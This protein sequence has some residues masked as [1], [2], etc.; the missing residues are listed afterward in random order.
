MVS[1]L[2]LFILVWVSNAHLCSDVQQS[3][4]NN[5]PCSIGCNAKGINCEKI[6]GAFFGSDAEFKF[7]KKQEC[8]GKNEYEYWCS[9]QEMFYKAHIDVVWNAKGKTND[10]PETTHSIVQC[11]K[12]I[13]QKL[14]CLGKVCACKVPKYSDYKPDPFKINTIGGTGGNKMEIK[15]ISDTKYGGG[16]Y[17]FPC[18]TRCKTSGK[19]TI[20]FSKIKK[21]IREYYEIQSMFHSPEYYCGRAS[22]NYLMNID[23]HKIPGNDQKKI[24]SL[25]G[26]KKDGRSGK[27]LLVVPAAGSSFVLCYS[28]LDRWD[29]DD[30]TLKNL[31]FQIYK[32]FADLINVTYPFIYEEVKSYMKKM[33]FL[34]SKWLSNGKWHA[35][36]KWGREEFEAE[37]KVK[38]LLKGTLLDTRELKDN[39]HAIADQLWQL[40]KKGETGK[41]Q[42]IMSIIKKVKI[43]Y[44]LW[45]LPLECA[46]T[47]I[48]K[49]K[50]ISI[51]QTEWQTIP[52]NELTSWHVQHFYSIQT[53]YGNFRKQEEYKNLIGCRLAECILAF[54]GEKFFEVTSQ[55]KLSEIINQAKKLNEKMKT[56]S[57][58][59]MDN[60]FV[61]D[62]I[63]IGLG[64]TLVW[65]FICFVFGLTAG[66]WLVI[67]TSMWNTRK[68]TQ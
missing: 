36:G 62:W 13:K 53:T 38:E 23:R 7:E 60:V 1:L 61:S 24:L 68:E 65:V 63:F 67:G 17:M 16:M 32:P 64:I 29:F 19:Q 43:K 9:K 11:A 48:F 21:K 45:K 3:L 50:P 22:K 58:T 26:K 4:K 35:K 37:D 28:T 52:F 56:Q 54:K 33:S 42:K 66:Y 18:S 12:D 41:E 6:L 30:Q 14:S 27:K 5:K 39:M 25:L 49:K 10:P 59:A 40:E 47:S 51:Q 31:G 2:L 57:K 46:E 44:Q 8:K 15:Y 55:T 20:P 34:K